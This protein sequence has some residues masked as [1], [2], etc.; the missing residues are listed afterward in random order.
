MDNRFDFTPIIARKIMQ[1][2]EP[3]QTASEWLKNAV[4]V[5]MFFSIMALVFAMI[6]YGVVYFVTATWKLFA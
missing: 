3:K 2:D 4:S 6:A 5:V 1:Q